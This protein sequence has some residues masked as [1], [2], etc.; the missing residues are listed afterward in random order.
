MVGYLLE[1][2][3]GVQGCSKVTV[4][5]KGSDARTSKRYSSLPV[6]RTRGKE[7]VRIDAFNSPTHDN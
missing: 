2:M 7:D 1:A 3:L 5:V 4:K 6:S